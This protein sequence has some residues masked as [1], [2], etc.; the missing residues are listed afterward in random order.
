VINL[1]LETR[2]R[3]NARYCC[4]A[5]FDMPADETP[6][7]AALFLQP[8]VERKGGSPKGCLLEAGIRDAFA[9]TK[10]RDSNC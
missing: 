6:P 10:V 5:A 4:V 8:A 3:F 9:G 2:N 7:M 1:S